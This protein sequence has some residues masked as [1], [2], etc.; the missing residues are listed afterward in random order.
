MIQSPNHEAIFTCSWWE[1]M[2]NPLIFRLEEVRRS[3]QIRPEEWKQRLIVQ[4][5]H[6]AGA[7]I[8]VGDLLTVKEEQFPVAVMLRRPTQATREEGVRS[9]KSKPEY[10]ENKDRVS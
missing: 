7:E 1:H 8:A 5:I 3:R 6:G 10:Y 9:F 4:S 2:K